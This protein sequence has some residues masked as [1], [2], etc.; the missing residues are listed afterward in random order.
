MLTREAAAGRVYV[1]SA[2]AFEIA[3]LHA[4]G[5]LAFN[6]PVEGWILES[7]DTAGLRVLDLGVHAAI[8]AGA[9]PADALPDP[10]DR[11]LVALAREAQ[12]PL[13][14]RD[15]AILDYARR[16]RLVKIVDAS[17]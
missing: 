17:A 15:R 3:A 2:S 16:T 10:L 9:I 5:R 8:D 12:V 7:I 11:L 6:R 14:T 1:T 13:A 4:A